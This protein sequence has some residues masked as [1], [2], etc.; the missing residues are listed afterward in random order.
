MIDNE[1]KETFLLIDR[2]TLK[3]EFKNQKDFDM[4]DVKPLKFFCIFGSITARDVE[5]LV[6]VSKA[7]LVA[8]ILGKKIYQVNSVKFLTML[9]EKHTDRK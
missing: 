7:N 8:T 2:T 3:S 6:L 9:S 5:F 1:N 4:K